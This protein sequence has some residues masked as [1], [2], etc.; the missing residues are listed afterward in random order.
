MTLVVRCACDT[1]SS[2][3]MKV[4]SLRSFERLCFKLMV[5]MTRASHSMSI[6]AG[7]LGPHWYSDTLK[8]TIPWTQPQ[9]PINSHKFSFCSALTSVSTP[10]RKMR[11]SNRPKETGPKPMQLTRFYQFISVWFWQVLT[12]RQLAGIRIIFCKNKK[13]NRRLIREYIQ[14]LWERFKPRRVPWGCSAD[15]DRSLSWSGSFEGT[16]GPSPETGWIVDDGFLNLGMS[17][18]ADGSHDFHETLQTGYWWI[19]NSLPLPWANFTF[20]YTLHDLHPQK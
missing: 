11:I 19:L 10:A 16:Q 18:H 3:W 2:V 20:I 9:N 7:P 5:Q 14:L 17:W 8:F 12:T 13:A 6:A 15:T 1:L 4:H